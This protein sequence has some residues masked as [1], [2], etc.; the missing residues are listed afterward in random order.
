MNSSSL[1]VA[2]GL[3][4]TTVTAATMGQH[5]MSALLQTPPHPSLQMLQQQTLPFPSHLFIQGGNNGINNEYNSR[6]GMSGNEGT[7]P[8]TL[9]SYG[10][11]QNFTAF[12]EPAKN[13]LAGMMYQQYAGVIVSFFAFNL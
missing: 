5:A 10:Q 2:A 3:D 9:D 7:L 6:N 8:Y 11:Q 13:V 1:N 12:A 4:E